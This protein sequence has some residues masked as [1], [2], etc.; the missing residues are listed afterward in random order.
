[1]LKFDEIN[2]SNSESLIDK[3][4]KGI[5]SIDSISDSETWEFI[6][7]EF[8]IAHLETEPYDYEDLLEEIFYCSEEDIEINYEISDKIRTILESFNPAKWEKLTKLE[9]ED[10]IKKFIKLLSDE[11]EIKSIPELL[12]SEYEDG[13]MGDYNVSTNTIT[14]NKNYIDDPYETLD[15]V[16]HEMRHAYQ[17]VR[18]NILETKEDALYKVNFLN[19]LSPGIDQNGF[20]IDF[21]DYYFQYIEVEARAFA[22]IFT[23]AI[24]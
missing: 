10:T 8:E 20:Y 18:A 22:E 15:T 21:I 1:M 2:Q 23:E 6:N 7:R 4:Y 17:H 16:A 11:L 5:K 13:S 19:Y 12:F 14:L 24:R 9:R 3:P